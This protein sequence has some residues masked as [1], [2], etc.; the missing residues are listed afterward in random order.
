MDIEK[1]KVTLELQDKM[2]QKL[3][4]ISKQV[5]NLAKDVE[6]ATNQMNSAFNKVNVG[7]GLSKSIEQF[8][9][10][11]SGL[12]NEKVEID[13]GAKVT[14]IDSSALGTGAMAIGATQMQGAVNGMNKSM[15]GIS[16]SVSK[17]SEELRSAFGASV[18]DTVSF[19]NRLK[20]IPTM[21]E[22]INQATQNNKI[23]NLNF[24]L[25]G[26]QIQHLQTYFNGFKGSVE[27]VNEALAVLN[28]MSD[29]IKK[30]K[31]DNNPDLYKNSLSNINSQIDE[32]LRLAKP[33]ATVKIPIEIQNLAE[34]ANKVQEQLAKITSKESV[35]KINTDSIKEAEKNIDSLEKKIDKAMRSNNPDDYAMGSTYASR[36]EE[37]I[38]NKKRLITEND[39]LQ[40]SLKKLYQEANAGQTGFDKLNKK[41]NE[42]GNSAEKSSKSI[43]KMSGAFGGLLATMKRLVPMFSLFGLINFGKQ[44]VQ[45]ASSIAEIQNVVDT[46]FKDSASVIDE[47]AERCSSAFGETTLEAKKYAS[48]FGAI[49]SS[50]GVNSKYLVE[51]SKNLAQ[52]SGKMLPFL[53]EMIVIII[54]KLSWESK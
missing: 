41:L 43:E 47:W 15:V 46:V 6:R 50:S 17:M 1:V 37:E 39:K 22:E 9:K 18:K 45:T 3:K 30:M 34:L 42:T 36:I 33:T 48:T 28:N 2:S 5:T 8:K 51:M 32:A 19:Q 23:G 13:V 16:A 53:S 20:M 14:G 54:A 49:F 29:V 40:S 38:D 21:F 11:L 24:D 12:K 35:I 4:D 44:A 52:L 31:V 27:G 10:Q 26:V 7:N 25:L